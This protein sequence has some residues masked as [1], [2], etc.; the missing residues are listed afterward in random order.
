MVALDVVSHL[1]VEHVEDIRSGPLVDRA[2]ARHDVVADAVGGDMPGTI[3]RLPRTPASTQ[4]NP[5][6]IP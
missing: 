1:P 2:H 3:G 6:S 5:L 4:F